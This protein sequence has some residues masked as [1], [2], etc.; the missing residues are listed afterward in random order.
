MEGTDPPLVERLR[1]LP[2]MAELPPEESEWL[3]ENGRLKVY[4]AGAV[5]APRGERLRHLFILLS[6]SL[7]VRVDRGTG[8]RRV[9]E[10]RV[11]DVT[12]M[13]PYSR[14]TASPGDV[15]AEEV[16]ELLAIDVGRFPDM[17]HRCPLFTS[18]TVHSMLDRARE[19]RA[20]DLHD[21]KMVSLGKLASGLAHELNNP[22]SAVVR[23]AKLLQEA[24][25]E[26]D[27]ATRAL[28]ERGVPPAALALLERV[29]AAA[30]DDVGV[31]GAG[32]VRT[33]PSALE[34]ADREDEISDWLDRHDCDESLAWPLME[35]A[36]TA[37][38]LEEFA[39]TLTGAE[40]DAGLK[41]VTSR[42]TAGSLADEVWRSATRIHDLVTVVKKFT[43]MDNLAV[44]DVVDV[45]AGLRD[46]IAVMAAR[47]GAAGVAITLA[48]EERLPRVEATGVE[49]NQ[50]WMALIDNALDVT[51]SEGGA[52]EVTAR[53]ELGRVV[54][55]VAD[56]GPGIAPDILTQIF[57][58]FFTT[59]PPGQ[60]IG[61]GLDIARRLVRQSLGEITV[62]S[63]PGRT[64]FRVSL[65]PQEKS[66]LT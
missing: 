20:S 30:E 31:S 65:I 16:T 64:E 63:R 41:W 46:T 33:P 21:E 14:M 47:A 66:P 51:S 1:A 43:Y 12:G 13:L 22:S 58:P 49:L 56:D 4:E 39:R 24:L 35:M 10:W 25:T 53:S 17:V 11:G 29:H 32:P 23:S 5:V 60:G 45:G 34:R 19:F 62:E 27:A 7:A 59:K 9:M 52:V 15:R 54:V 38:E 28:G 48:V 40:L 55:Q 36:V 37:A 50:V 42:F 6:G 57:D 44:T 61:M 18:G 3:V 8:L 26:S 2:F